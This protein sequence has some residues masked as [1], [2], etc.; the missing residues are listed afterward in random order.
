MKISPRA[1]R[2]WLRME[3]LFGDNL[4]LLHPTGMPDSWA[5]VV[6]R[7][8]DQTVKEG[9]ARLKHFRRPPSPREFSEV[10]DSLPT[11]ASAPNLMPR[12]V[13]Y[14][15][16]NLNLTQQQYGVPWT[17]VY[18]GDSRPGSSH[19]AIRGVRIPSDPQ[20]GRAEIFLP[21]EV[22]S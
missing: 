21:I 4:K 3:Q 7:V 11:P 18:E 15:M 20:A 10:M 16:K 13:D 22:I 8:D 9:L 12:L 2:V 14:A 5:Q 19:F 1:E 17:W 6:D